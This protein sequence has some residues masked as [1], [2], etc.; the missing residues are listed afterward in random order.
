MHTVVTPLSWDAEHRL[1]ADLVATP[2][3]EQSQARQI[4]FPSIMYST[5][6]QG[7]LSRREFI[8]LSSLLVASLLIPGA[9]AKVLASEGSF[10]GEVEYVT[11]E[12]GVIRK[13]DTNRNIVLMTYDD[14]GKA[15]YI[16]TILDAYQSFRSQ[17]TFFVTGA[18]LEKNIE[19]AAEIVGQGHDLGFH[20]W[21]HQCLTELKSDEL[22]EQFL[23]F[24]E[25]KSKFELT[26][27]YEIIFF[28]PPYGAYNKKVLSL[29]REQ[30]MYTVLWSL[31]SGGLD[32]VEKTTKRVVER[33]R[34]GAIV[35]SHSTRWGD[36]YSCKPILEAFSAMG[37]RSV[38]LREGLV[39]KSVNLREGFVTK[40][41]IDFCTRY[42]LDYPCSYWCRDGQ[43]RARQGP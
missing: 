28:R 17:S 40:E 18:W 19:L 32:G 20:G 4:I 27:G 1:F 9:F 30:G 10:E 23:K 41:E 13:G 16:K 14:G 33:V 22:K 2:I 36:V 43:R 26:T 3:V 12:D 39:T 38:N 11:D 34:K 24:E 5:M 8:K 29:A 25:V 42:P 37:M 6:G 35:L 21:D 31:E 15:D 7:H